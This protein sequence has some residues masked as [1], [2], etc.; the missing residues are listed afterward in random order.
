MSPYRCI[1]QEGYK[2]LILVGAGIN[3]ENDNVDIE[4]VFNNQERYSATYF[5]I[6]NIQ[7][8]MERYTSTGECNYG[9]YFWAIDMVIVRDL[10]EETIVE[11]IRTMVSEGT[12]KHTFMFLENDE[13]N[14][15]SITS[16]C[17]E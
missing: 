3:P 15:S 6:A 4:V 1:E 9:Q 17:S 16:L 5:T 11:S 14:L 2:I 12:L 13:D 10:R 7:S 8:L